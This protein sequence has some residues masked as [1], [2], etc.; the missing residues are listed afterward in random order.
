MGI[1]LYAYTPTAHM[2]TETSVA[3]ADIERPLAA[4]DA[5]KETPLKPYD[6]IVIGAGSGG[7]GVAGF[8]A[9]IG[10]RTLLIDRSDENIGGDCLNHGCVPS[11]ALIHVAERVH[12]ARS[13]GMFGLSTSGDVDM[14]LVKQHIRG[15][16]D[17]I[18]EHENAAYLRR[19]GME[20]ALG[21]AA[22]VSDRDVEVNGRRYHG[23]KIIIATGSRPRALKVP[24]IEKV[25]V[26]TNEHIFTIDRIPKRMLVI[27]AGPIGMEVGQAFQRIGAQ[28]TMVH[29][30][31]SA[32]KHDHPDLVSVVQA[33][34]EAEGVRFLFNAEP[35]AFPT[36]K[37]ASV[38]AA[39]DEILHVEF[40][41]V[42]VAIGREI[43]IRDLQLHNAGVK[44]ENGRIVHDRYLR[45]SN[46][47]I[48]VCGD[49]AGELMFSHAA[50]QHMRL[51]INNFISPFKQ[52]LDDR[53]MSWVTF[54]DPQLATFGLSKEKLE[55]K[56][57]PHG[58]LQMEFGDDDRAVIERYR[59]SRMIL[60]VSSGLFRKKRI[61]GGA[62]VAPHAGELV[63]ELILAMRTGLSIDAIFDKIYPYP[64]A[65]RVVQ[66]IIVKEK[67]KGLKGL[68]LPFLRLLFR[69]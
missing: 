1:Y 27:G 9:R 13:A 58:T 56:K 7:L 66:Q 52:K 12:A 23:N 41:A 45:T 40:D 44:V 24:G 54:T 15:A 55:E 19:Q 69:L 25:H 62:M 33:R 42:F 65:A 5:K 37:S 28:V 21:T 10:L 6:V 34:M 61:L 11:K 51:L 8:A 59:D 35:V 64:V 36:P 49:V 30:G 46:R 67:E 31:P 20:L 53:H 50:E 60:Y 63:Q 22:F 2:E 4:R 14:H 47:R 29:K 68:I 48:H 17:I 43:A 38:R 32:L 3:E 57:I 16:Q 39:N 26:L 18:R